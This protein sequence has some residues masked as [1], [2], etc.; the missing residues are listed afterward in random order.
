MNVF[1]DRFVH[2]YSFF[3]GKL[4]T[5][6]MDQKLYE[7]WIFFIIF[8]FSYVIHILAKITDSVPYR[9]SCINWTFL[10]TVLFIYCAYL[11]ISVISWSAGWKIDN[12]EMLTTASIMIFFSNFVYM[13]TLL[14]TILH[15]RRTCDEW[16][17]TTIV[18]FNI[19]AVSEVKLAFY[20]HIEDYLASE[21]Y[22]SSL[23]ASIVWFYN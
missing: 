11:L 6:L 2:C 20:K 23:Y 7:K 21:W 17:T 19:F 5:Q 3:L 1:H 9:K 16:I 10:I 8:L 4:F 12:N 22:W 15:H 14:P 18:L 13:W